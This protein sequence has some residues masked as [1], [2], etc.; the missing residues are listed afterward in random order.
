MNS[1]LLPQGLGRRPKKDWPK[2]KKALAIGKGTPQEL[3]V[4]R[5]SGPSVPS[6]P[7]IYH[8]TIIFD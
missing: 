6:V 5:R 3:K 2:A 8:F 4:S 1:P 7:S